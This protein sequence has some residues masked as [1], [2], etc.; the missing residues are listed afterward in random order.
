MNGP[1][2]KNMVLLGKGGLSPGIQAVDLLSGKPGGSIILPYGHSVY[3][4]AMEW[5]TGS[6]AIGTKLGRVFLIS[7]LEGEGISHSRA[8][9]QGAPVLSLSWLHKSTL[10][11]SDTAGR[12]LVWDTHPGTLPKT[13]HVGAGVICSLI[14][15]PNDELAGLSTEGNLHFWDS[16]KGGL[17]RSI[18]CYTPSHISALVHLR[19]WRAN[20]TLVYPAEDG[21]LSFCD[22]RTFEMSYVKGHEGTVYATWVSGEHLLSMGLEDKRLKIWQVRPDRHLEDFMMPRGAIALFTPDDSLKKILVVEAD[23]SAVSYEIN[24]A[25]PTLLRHFA[26]KDYRVMMRCYPIQ[27]PS[28]VHPQEEEIRRISEDILDKSGQIPNDDLENMHV[29]L[30]GL[31]YEHVSLALK[32]DHAEKQGN[33]VES[34]QLRSLLVDLL[35]KDNPAVCLSMERYAATLVKLW[36]LPEANQVC[37]DILGIYPSYKFSIRPQDITEM[38]ELM[39]GSQWLIAPDFPIELIIDSAIVVGKRFSGSYIINKLSQEDCGEWELT[40][41]VIATKYADVCREIGIRKLPTASAESR[42]YLSRDGARK[43]DI[44]LFGDGQTNR[45]KGL[46]FALEVFNGNPGT[47]VVPL[48]LFDWPDSG[49]AGSIEEENSQALTTLT[50]IRDGYKPNAYLSAVHKAVKQAL[51]RLIT[52]SASKRSV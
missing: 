1:V 37:M 11:V 15:L 25:S 50:R 4:I 30:T 26:G 2:Q 13:L 51:R 29:R 48:V 39:A 9:A 49:K 27:I 42:I 22:L 5:E 24:E 34:L 35:D 10:A 19:Y 14:N 52:E 23:G 40:S 47:R 43:I 3:T 44:I 28:L 16:F 21:Y 6:I 46:Q 41:T 7:S 17:L 8:L 12:V 38:A 36:H 20:H 32:A 45:I 18:D 33:L 31:G